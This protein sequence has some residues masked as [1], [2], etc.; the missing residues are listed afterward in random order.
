[1]SNRSQ[2]PDS[3]FDA[4]S[5]MSDNTSHRETGG[6]INRLNEA[7][8]QI[9]LVIGHLRDESKHVDPEQITEL[10]RIHSELRDVTN[11]LDEQARVT[12]TELHGGDE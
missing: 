10:E 8:K 9:S 1:M 7:D 11:T 2:T 4:Y 12:A 6:P 5:N 3:D